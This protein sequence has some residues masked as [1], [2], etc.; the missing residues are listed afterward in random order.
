VLLYS[1]SLPGAKF[2]ACLR[3]SAKCI[4]VGGN[5]SVFEIPASSISVSIITNPLLIQHCRIV[6]FAHIRQ[7]PGD[8]FPYVH[9]LQKASL[10]SRRSRCWRG[11]LDVTDI[12]KGL[13]LMAVFFQWRGQPFPHK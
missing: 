12:E 1:Q 9:R 13:R 2:N 4:L 11:M 5:L 6:I 3:L 10:F 7:I 8:N